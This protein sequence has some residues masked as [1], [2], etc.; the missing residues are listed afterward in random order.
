MRTN[1]H[2][3]SGIRTHDLSVKAVK[4]YASA[5]AASGTGDY[6]YYYYYYYYCYNYPTGYTVHEPLSNLVPKSHYIAD[7]EKNI[8]NKLKLTPR[9]TF[10]VKKLIVVHAVDKFPDFYGSSPSLLYQ[11]E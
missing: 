6:Y 9:S 5:S 1:I 10:L 3:S 8:G 11:R 7:F 2:A 4:V